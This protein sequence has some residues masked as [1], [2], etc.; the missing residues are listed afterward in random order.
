MSRENP[1][2]GER[3]SWRFEAMAYDLVVLLL[4]ACR[5]TGPRASVAGCFGRWGR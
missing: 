3:I 1:T 5:W 2:L 4:R